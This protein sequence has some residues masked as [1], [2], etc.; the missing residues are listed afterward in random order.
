[1]KIKQNWKVYKTARATNINKTILGLYQE[2]PQKP[3]R[4]LANKGLKHFDFK[5]KGIESE[6]CI[7]GEGNHWLE[8]EIV[9]FLEEEREVQNCKKM[10]GFYLV[11]DLLKLNNP[12]LDKFLPI[13]LT[14]RRGGKPRKSIIAS[15]GSLINIQF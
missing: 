9:N 5:F 3:T 13:I 8:K 14:A 15:D 2:Q 11:S 6:F 10:G 4:T 1:M 12:H 7:D